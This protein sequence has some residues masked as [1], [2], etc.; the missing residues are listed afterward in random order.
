MAL[1]HT[2][3]TN[4]STL[5]H[6]LPLPPLLQCWTRVHAISPEFQRILR[7]ITVLFENSILKTLKINAITQV[8]QGILSTIVDMPINFTL[9]L[10][11]GKLKHFAC[12]E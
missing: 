8:S 10:T 2:R 5:V 6:P 11:Q 1:F 3:K 4:S 7:G 9:R 12:S